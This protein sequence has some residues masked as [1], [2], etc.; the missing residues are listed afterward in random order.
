MEVPC[1]LTAAASACIAMSIQDFALNGENLSV[2]CRYWMHA[3]VISV[4]SLICWVHKASV[5]YCYVNEIVARR[6][7]EA[8]Q[9]NP[10]LL[11]VYCVRSHHVIWNKPTLF[12][13][14]WELRYGLWKHF[15]DSQ[16]YN[17]KLHM[18]FIGMG[19][20]GCNHLI[21]F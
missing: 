13:E 8:P 17:F 18:T 16:V 2:T 7:K 15:K 6:A 1:G 12:F 21:V 14:D 4:M 5:L 10:P 3:I 9:L 19:T 20:A 11:T